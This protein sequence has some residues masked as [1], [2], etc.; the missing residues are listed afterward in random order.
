MVNGSFAYDWGP[1]VWPVH[2]KQKL[3]MYSPIYFQKVYSE[4]SS[5]KVILATAEA[6]LR[7]FQQAPKVLPQHRK[8]SKC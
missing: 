1:F 2:D 3:T 8:Q 7:F 5:S 6:D 4:M